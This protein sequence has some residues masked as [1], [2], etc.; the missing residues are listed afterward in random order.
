MPDARDDNAAVAK[1]L[2][3]HVRTVQRWKA[4]WT[5][6]G[7]VGLASKGPP[8]HPQLSDEQLAALEAEL[9]RGP[10]TH[11]RPGPDLDVEVGRIR[12]ALRP[13]ATSSATS[14]TGCCRW[15]SARWFCWPAAR[16]SRT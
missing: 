12:T 14:R 6:G 7:Q 5:A 9:E 4:A 13:G 10:V 16:M 2:R 1:A 8:K 15:S 3:L 11:G